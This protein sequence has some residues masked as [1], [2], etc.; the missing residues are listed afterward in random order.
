MAEIVISVAAKVA[1]L[2]VVPIK[3]HICYPFKYESNI[4]GLKK[5]LEN[6]TNRRE[7]VHHSVDEAMRQG[8]EI[9]KHVEKWMHSVDEFTE[10]V[11]KPIIDDQHKA[12]K[13]CSIGFCYNLMTR[14]SLSKKAAK[15]KKEGFDLLGQGKF[16]K[17][18][19]RPPLHRAISIYTR[20][21]EDFD[22]RKPIFQEIMQTLKGDNFNVI[23]V[24]MGGVGKIT[25]VKSVVAQTI[26]DKLFDVVEW[27]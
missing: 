2:L 6:L 8:D 15:T 18:S 7:V 22:S 21:Y 14:Y 11:V 25:L 13:L 26:E 9:E 20:D 19:Y 5:Q 1:E 24:C 3:K 23:G 12:G 16:N 4:E 27:L 10:G 17:V